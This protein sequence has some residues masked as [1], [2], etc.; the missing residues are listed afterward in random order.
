MARRA[1]RGRGGKLVIGFLADVATVSARSNLPAS[2]RDLV[3]SN[4]DF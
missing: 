4:L 3:E 2:V 1:S